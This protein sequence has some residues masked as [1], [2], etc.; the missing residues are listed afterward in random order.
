M[1]TLQGKNL[2]NTSHTLPTPVHVRP[3]YASCRQS[4][5]VATF[6]ESSIELS[7]ST[8]PEKKGSW[9]NPQCIVNRSV[10]PYLA[11]LLSQPMKQWG[12]SQASMNG[13]LLELLG[14]YHQYAIDIFNTCSRGPTKRS[15]TDTSGG[16]NLGG[17]GFPHSTARPSR[18]VVSP[19]P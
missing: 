6:H 19:F 9:H 16:Y 18:P 1:Y 13:Q 2:I 8:T 4:P 5:Y 3:V 12:Q 10:G 14:P 17:A 15:L 11:S 7:R